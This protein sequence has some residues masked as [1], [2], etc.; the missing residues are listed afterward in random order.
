MVRCSVFAQLACAALTAAPVLAHGQS[1]SDQSSAITE[2]DISA[3]KAEL[4]RCASALRHPG[5]IPELRKSL[6][7][8]WTVQ[9]GGSRFEISTQSLAADL[10]R[11]EQNPEKAS[12]AARDLQ[13][14]LSA[15]RKA[16]EEF[17]NSARAASPSNARP[18]LDEILNRREFAGAIGPSE[19]QILMARIERWIFERLYWLLSRLHL[20]GKAGNFLA[21]TVVVLAF[22]ALAYWVIRNFSRILRATTI[23]V[24]GPAPS[25][26]SRFWVKDALAAAEHGDYR[27]AVHCAYWAAIVKLE[28]LGMLKRDH[29]RTPRES[30]LLLEPFPKEQKLLGDFTRHF[31]L[32]WYGYRPASLEDWSG[33]RA[34]LEKMGCLTHSTA[35]TAS[36]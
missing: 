1:N 21:W 2:L 17:E 34:H 29:A 32:I 35:A 3:Y 30:L 22:L 27:E 28:G 36:S 31:E 23:P 4:D 15:M 18:H 8:A 6:P 7:R 20:Q 19:F 26:D 13:L 25:D 11:I 5:A 12:S 9:A 14:R 10:R 33:A 16:A 24:A